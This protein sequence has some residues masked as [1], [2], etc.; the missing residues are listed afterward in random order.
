MKIPV[1]VFCCILVTLC[2]CGT[3]NNLAFDDSSGDDEPA[4]DEAPEPE[5]DVSTIYA[6]ATDFASSGQL[7]AGSIEDGSVSLTNTGITLL[8]SSATVRV[9]A[10]Q[11]FILHDGWSLISSDNLQILNP[12]SSFATM[13]QYSTGNGTNPHDVAVSGSSAFIS[14]YNPTADPDNV[15]GSGNPGDVIEMNIE[16][17]AITHR[18][19]F[20]DF[21]TADGDLNANADQM[22]LQDG[23]LYVALQDLDASTF[24][25]SSA[26]KIGMIDVAT[27]TVLGTITL[28]GRNPVSLAISEDGN[29]LFVANMATYDFALGNFDTSTPYG[30]IEI[31]DLEHETTDLF[32]D[33]EDLGGY[34]ERVRAGDGRIFAVAST[35]DPADF[36]YSSALLQMPQDMDALDDVGELEDSGNDIREIAVSGHY[37]WVSR[38][39]INEDGA[40]SPRVVIYDLDTDG[41]LDDVLE[42]VAAVTSM[43][44]M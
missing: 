2:S 41:L 20:K 36:S 40:S 10:D 6:F 7:Y 28:S 8:G 34:V 9:S 14:L 17:G 37:L 19:S 23:L 13:G 29:R 25:A 42:P 4:A 16:S 1:T 38:R 35:L 26:G 27:H 30:G 11:V 22:V 43:A 12:D 44:G 21:L 15:D 24:A 39:E 18:Y 33:D 5:A 3:V 32:L 31:V